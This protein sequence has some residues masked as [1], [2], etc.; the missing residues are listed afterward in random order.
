MAFVERPI[1]KNRRRI[2]TDE[3]LDELKQTATNGKAVVIP[4]DGVDPRGR[5]TT[6]ANWC[7]INRLPIRTVLCN[8]EL[9]A[10]LEPKQ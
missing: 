10:W 8:G 5:Q 9:L 1:R 7:R 4:T 3:L 2:I 6:I